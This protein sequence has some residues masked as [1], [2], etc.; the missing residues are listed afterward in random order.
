[1]ETHLLSKYGCSLF[2]V[3]TKNLLT[4]Q[5]EVVLVLK[6][7]AI[8]NLPGIS[9]QLSP[10]HTQ[11]P[12][13]FYGHQFVHCSSARHIALLSTPSETGKHDQN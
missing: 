2:V 11:S 5:F 10:H 1:M 13:W 7:L 4:Q 8:N 12:L 6:M 9:D 3:I